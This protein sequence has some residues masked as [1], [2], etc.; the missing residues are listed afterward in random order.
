MPYIQICMFYCFSVV[1]DKHA[2]DLMLLIVDFCVL[3]MQEGLLGRIQDAFT[4]IVCQE[5][6]YQPVTTTCS[7]N[8]CKVQTHQSLIHL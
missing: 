7:H 1:K 5:L 6:V 4:C 8:L 3:F 2:V